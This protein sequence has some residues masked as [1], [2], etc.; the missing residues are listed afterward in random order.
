MV[1]VAE[2]TIYEGD[3][4]PLL[5]RFVD[6]FGVP[7]KQSSVSSWDL[8]IFDQNSSTPSSPVYSDLGNAASDVIYDTPQTSD[9]WRYAKPFNFN[10]V[11]LAADM[12]A[13]GFDPSGGRTYVFQVSL[14]RT[15][16]S[17]KRG[18]WRVRFEPTD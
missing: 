6:D 7:I 17:I 4:V 16:G 10:L 18:V 8:R 11:V 2:G 9:S 13:A 3:N 12:T 1:Y 15:D 14:N 5:A